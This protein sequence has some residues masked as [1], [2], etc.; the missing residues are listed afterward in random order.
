[1]LI[2]FYFELNKIK[3]NTMQYNFYIFC[4]SSKHLTLLIYALIMYIILGYRLHLMRLIH[5][6][7][8][9][10]SWPKYWKQL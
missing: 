6:A 1:M 7:K 5:I 8:L 9:P 4:Y 10:R 2:K 3:I